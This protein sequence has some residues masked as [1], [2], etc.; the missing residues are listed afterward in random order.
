MEKAGARDRLADIGAAILL[1]ALNVFVAWRLFFAEYTPHFNSVEGAFI[2]LARYMSRHLGHWSWY[3]IWNCG[4]PFQDTYVPLLH[5]A[6]ALTSM[7]TGA[8]AAHAYHM[9]TA[10]V[11]CLAPVT[12]Y[13]M[14]RGLGATPVAALFAALVLSLFSPTAAMFPEY[15]TDL[16]SVF[17]PRRFQV[18]VLYGEGP[19]LTAFAWIPLVIL[20]L[21]NSI[22]KRTGRAFA[23][24]ALAMALV[25]VSNAPGTMALGIGVFC[26]ICIQYGEQ[27]AAWKIAIGAT[28]LAYA[29]S[30]FAMPPSSLATVAAN[31]GSMHAGWE[32]SFNYVVVLMPLLL[33]ATAGAGW[34]LGRVGAPRYVAFGALYFGLLTAL[35]WTARDRRHF[36]LLPQAGRM[37]LELEMGAALVLGWIGW[38]VFRVRL[39]RYAVLGFGALAIYHQIHWYRMGID[40]LLPADDLASHSEYMSARWVR[41]HLGNKRVYAAGSTA[42]WLNAFTETP[43]VNG[44]C[45]QGR[46]MRSLQ[47]VPYLVTSLTSPEKTRL[48]ITWLQAMGAHAMI[49]NGP[50]SGDD[51]KDFKEPERFDAAATALHRELGD[52]IYQIPQRNDSLAHVLHTGEAAPV[53]PAGVALDSD[54]VRYAAAIEDPGHPEAQCAW[55]DPGHA[56]IRATLSRGD[57]VSVQMEYVHGWKASV[58]GQSR[59]VRADGIGFVLIEPECEGDC[60]IDLQWT[61][62]WDYYV[63]AFVSLAGLALAAVL[64]WRGSSGQP[65]SANAHA[66]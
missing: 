19:H 55:P 58:G 46:S 13:F 31:S 48:S 3:P 56:R 61:G 9:V 43:Q 18:L 65:V 4:M 39:A 24:V 35:V 30:C 64:L 66:C 14:A 52:T 6:V 2:G 59:R 34:L 28:V 23:L 15:A 49:V 8:S 57:V 26:R 21:E 50:Q 45:D 37:H 29:I 54:V 40:A 33:A 22:R 1:Y 41:D 16:G 51:Y 62:P 53:Q 17:L 5:L 11:Y 10:A 44:C 12:F 32:H 7:A 60:E 25:F 20:A 42:F 38:M 63:T 36:E 47:A 27:L